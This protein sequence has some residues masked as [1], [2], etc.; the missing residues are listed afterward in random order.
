MGMPCQVNS[1]L[2]LK[3]SQG[4]PSSLELNTQYQVKKKGYRIFPIDVP[5]MLVDDDWVAY[6]DVVIE[7]L[8]WHGEMTHLAFRIDRIYS[9]P[10]QVKV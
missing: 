10:F 1:I 3:S 4:Y 6:A 5:I 7:T 2:K 9:A 8:T